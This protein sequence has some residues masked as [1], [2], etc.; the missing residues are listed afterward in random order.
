MRTTGQI[1]PVP[2]IPLVLQ[3]TSPRFAPDI[4]WGSGGAHDGHLVLSNSPESLDDS[5]MPGPVGTLYQDLSA[6]S[7]RGPAPSSRFLAGNLRVFV[8]HTNRT[9]RRLD[10]GFTVR[11][12]TARPGRLTWY[13][14]SGQGYATNAVKLAQA[15]AYAWFADG[16]RWSVARR[17]GLGPGALASFWV[18]GVPPPCPLGVATAMMWYALR[19]RDA[20]GDPLAMDIQVWAREHGTLDPWGAPPLEPTG[21]VRATLPHATGM[22]RF[23]YDPDANGEIAIDMDSQGASE[24]PGL[25][26][27]PCNRSPYGWP[28]DHPRLGGNCAGPPPYLVGGGVALAPGACTTDGGG[29]PRWCYG[30]DPLGFD[31][32]SP[33]RE[34]LAGWDWLDQSLDGQ[35]DPTTPGLWYPSARWRR[36]LRRWNYG[37]YGMEVTFAFA[38]PPPQRP[39]RVGLVPAYAPH[40]IPWAWYDRTRRRAGQVPWLD[41]AGGRLDPAHQYI[42]AD[43]VRTA[44]FTT[45]LTAGAY[46]PLRI[47]LQRPG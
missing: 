19:L 43:G 34:Y 13:R 18:E 44:N 35:P 3:N 41:V 28:A 40:S 29:G 45:T 8:F 9:T 1:V 14:R 30:A 4:A 21:A 32:A 12:A 25:P 23:P 5:V 24:H 22:V 38:A 6:S 37:E 16:D 15:L 36:L 47:V 27:G 2:A 17:R 33:A 26:G 42:L 20:A 10:I 39:F 46:G 11:N 7:Q 31:Q